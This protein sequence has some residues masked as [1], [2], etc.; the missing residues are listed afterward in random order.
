MLTFNKSN[1]LLRISQ[2]A[3]HVYMRQVNLPRQTETEN[4]RLERPRQNLRK[5]NLLSVIFRYPLLSPF[6]PLNKTNP[7]DYQYRSLRYSKNASTSSALS[8]YITAFFFLSFVGQVRK[9]L[10]VEDSANERAPFAFSRQSSAAATRFKGNCGRIHVYIVTPIRVRRRPIGALLSH[11]NH[12]T[13]LGV[14][15]VPRGAY[16]NIFLYFKMITFYFFFSFFFF[17]WSLALSFTLSLSRSV[18]LACYYL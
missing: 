9:K 7:F 8:I 1:T 14:F 2:P 13:R 15:K 17:F 11:A 5:C 18:S 4:K 12:R 6:Q 10:H 16:R 3:G